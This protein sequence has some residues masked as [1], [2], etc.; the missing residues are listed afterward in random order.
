MFAL[1]GYRVVNRIYESPRTRIFAAVREADDQSVILKMPG[2]DFAS[3]EE[4]ARFL[5]EYEILRGLRIDGVICAHSLERFENIPVLVLEDFNGLPLSEI[6]RSESVSIEEALNLS[7]ALSS[8][9]GAVHAAGIIH[10][11]INPSNIIWNR[12]KGIVKLIDF[13]LS[14]RL[15]RE[16]QEVGHGG[17]I[18]GT[19]AYISPEQT[20]RVNRSIDFRTDY[21]SLG[22]TLYHLLSGAPPFTSA[23]P[24]ELIHCHIARHP[25]P[26]TDL[27]VSGKDQ[28]DR[29][30]QP[31]SC[32][33]EKLMAKS[34]E[35]RYASAFGLRADLEQARALL[36]SGRSDFVAGL[37]DRSDEF[38]IPERLY[39]FDRL[40]ERLH[41]LYQSVNRRQSVSLSIFGESGAGKTALV[42]EIH[43]WITPGHGFFIRGKYQRLNT[44][45]PYS[46]IIAMLRDLCVQLLLEPEDRLKVWQEEIQKAVRSNGQI[47]IDLVPELSL[48]MGP[49]PALDEPG[50]A[51]A[52]NRFLFT[53]GSFIRVFASG[54]QPLVLMLD[55]L[56]WADMASLHLIQNIATARDATNMF[57]IGLYRSEEVEEPL[58]I[59]IDEIRKIREVHEIYV[60]PLSIE[61]VLQMI[62]DTFRCTPERAA[63]L[64]VIVHRFGQGNPFF[65]RE[66][67]KD[68]Y[69]SGIVAFDPTSGEWKW[70]LVRFRNEYVGDNVVELLR[71]RL[72]RLSPSAR[73]LLSLAACLGGSFD[74]Q[75]LD[76]LHEKSRRQTADAMWEA[77]EQGIIIP[78][79]ANYRIFHFL[80]SINDNSMSG[81]DVRYRFQHDRL[82]QASYDQIPD[83]DKQT[84]HLRI[85][86]LLV[87]HTDF[88]KEPE[89]LLDIVHHLN[90]ALPLI[91][92]A[93]ELQRV[94]YYNLIA[95]EKARAS[96]AYAP[97]LQFNSI[98][99]DLLPSTSWATDYELTDRIYRM[100]AKLQYLCGRSAEADA[101]CRQIIRHARG[102][103]DKAVVREM[104]AV[105]YNYLWRMKDSINACID[106]LRYLNVNISESPST[107]T[108]IY[109]LLRVRLRL[110]GRRLEDLAAMPEIEDRNVRLALKLLINFIPSAYMSGNANLF[111]TA[112]L[113]KTFLAIRHGNSIETAGAYM[114]YG[115]L[116]AGMGDFQGAYDFGNLALKI[117][118]KYT[119]REWKSMILNL[120][121]LF[122]VSWNEHW[123][124]LRVHFSKAL[125]LGLSSGDWLYVSFAAGFINLWNPEL[126][127]KSLVAENEHYLSL[128]ERANV[129]TGFLSG[130]TNHQK[131][132]AYR[133]LTRVRGSLSDGE[134]DEDAILQRIVDIEYESGVGIFHLNKM[135]ICFSFEL[136]EKAR[137]HRMQGDASIQALAGSP[138]LVSW[139][140]F[141]FL[142]DATLMDGNVVERRAALR[143]MRREFH[144]MKRWADHNPHNFL[145]LKLLM[146]AELAKFRRRYFDAVNLYNRAIE[147][148]LD[149]RNLHHTALIYEL[150]ARFHLRYGVNHAARELLRSAYNH[151]RV[152]GATGK[153]SQL[154]EY[155]GGLLLEDEKAVLVAPSSRS[156]GS[157]SI[158]FESSTLIKASMAISSEIVL[159][160]LLDR[161]IQISL[162]NAGADRGI[163]F[164]VRGGSIFQVATG[165]ADRPT[166]MVD[167]QDL[168]AGGDFPASVIRYV[169]RTREHLVIDDATTDARF[170]KDPFIVEKQPKSLLCIGVVHL[171]DP[172]AILYLENSHVRGAFTND[173]IALL[174]LLSGQMAASIHNAELY[175]SLDQKV[176][177]RTQ[178]LQ[179]ERNKLEKRNLV[180]ERDIALAKK[181]QYSLIP[182][183]PPLHTM[184]TFYRPMEQLGGDFFDFI[185]LPDS[186]E[187]GIFL[188]D[189]SGHGVTAAFITSMIKTVLLQAGDRLS[190]P[191]SL[192]QYMNDVLFNQ[193]SGNFVT[194]FYGIY[195]PIERS[196]VYSSAG[197]NSP[198]LITSDGVS[199]ILVQPRIP[200]A[201]FSNG[202]MIARNRS[203]SN[204]RLKLPSSG[205]L[206]FYTDGL[207]EA[208]STV[209]NDFFGESALNKI[210]L[211]SL[212]MPPT[213]FRDHLCHRLE[214]FHGSSSFEDDVCFISLDF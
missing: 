140:L 57:F 150:A 75:T 209:G 18:E 85:G 61:A 163:M 70:D 4:I 184:S 27:P 179:I 146:E 25:T 208:R 30:P 173:R 115:V 189:V 41:S 62:C 154:E 109:M 95:A 152:W 56:Q 2:S 199:E 149:Y 175:A 176:Q 193:T 6:I 127:L 212:H 122:S 1:S 49:Q 164:L 142:T 124:E 103:Y 65:T 153:V 46:G 93:E 15:E 177:E 169:A 129:E 10:K 155:Y 66:L 194:I 165:F 92:D 98:A 73:T 79:T 89:K 187:M 171:G 157:G 86:R 37:Y 9:L 50:P 77:L 144:R 105:H 32:I 183:F 87:K 126:D 55:D 111:A 35:E 29:I 88:E 120:Y 16:K 191:A 40:I 28:K 26:L 68:M 182:A 112:I 58:R 31:L 180:M 160:R 23:D 60:E 137:Y 198:F 64:T 33:V 39:G 138:Y 7:I 116:L 123:R 201:V 90:Y 143:R 72:T 71:R 81:S 11:D 3:P 20:G 178:E 162:E 12:K 80:E 186:E 202:E 117:S 59:L 161:L 141:S 132:L 101:V 48:V 121:A 5:S 52:H 210:L 45:V 172:V 21:Y 43:R 47:L 53:I 167:H 94:R 166:E 100:Q 197:H 114:G 207:L 168:D 118:D 91:K 136:F 14:S 159:E 17:V 170:F 8:A 213:M 151:Y 135:E 192:I 139:S 34:P 214:Q 106:G 188:S 113:T 83:E 200:V 190:D 104:Q 131:W 19:A 36:E 125:E 102:N 24:T 196:L 96:N 42:N 67:L 145:H 107:A 158:A 148:A 211:D 78:L 204:T 195:D 63:D 54:E 51:E 206:L 99:K 82:R 181:I 22:V 128:L 76:V 185:R 134:Y 84:F 156:S 69:D 119:G 133:G 174:Q 108:V 97:A 205:R 38:R 130:R 13:G 44:D 203:Y 110:R 147:S 74:F